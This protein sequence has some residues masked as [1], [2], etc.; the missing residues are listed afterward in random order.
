MEQDNENLRAALDYSIILQVSHMAWRLGAA[1]RRFWQY[2]GHV[3]EGRGWL[4]AILDLPD[5]SAEDHT[6]ARAETLHAAGS[7]ARVQGDF[8]EAHHL[9]DDSLE[10]RRRF[11][12]LEGIAVSLDGLGVVMMYEGQYSLAETYLQESLQICRD[13]GSEAEAIKR[14]NDLGIVAMLQGDYEKAHS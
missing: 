10:I 8:A 1:L 5:K 6:L 4:K 14:I 12:D 3:D 7:L 11:S 13:L 9:L 2:H